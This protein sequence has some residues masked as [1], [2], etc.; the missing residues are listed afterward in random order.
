M[1]SGEWIARTGH[2]ETM[3]GRKETHRVLN[4]GQVEGLMGE[5]FNCR[6]ASFIS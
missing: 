1:T 4:I 2:P 5:S 6:G 3:P